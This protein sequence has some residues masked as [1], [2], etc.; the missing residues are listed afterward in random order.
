MSITKAYNCL[1]QFLPAAMEWFNLARKSGRPNILRVFACS[2]RSYVDIGEE[3]DWET[4][5]RD[6]SEEEEDDGAPEEAGAKPKRRGD[7]AVRERGQPH[8][9]GVLRLYHLIDAY[10]TAIAPLWP[11]GCASFL[12]SLFPPS[13]GRREEGRRFEEAGGGGPQVP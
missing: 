1:T 9:A 10:M 2:S 4:A 13:T 12:N 7:R 3:E 8:V 6:Y 11:P 5:D